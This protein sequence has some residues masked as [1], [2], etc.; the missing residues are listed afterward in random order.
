M[1][2]GL[3]AVTWIRR[4]SKHYYVACPSGRGPMGRC[5]CMVGVSPCTSH[6][7][8]HRELTIITVHS[9][10][11]CCT[12]APSKTGVKVLHHGTLRDPKWD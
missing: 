8:M 9:G 10:G 4:V 6:M 3:F 2:L 1:W 12:K 5:R 11:R 7:C